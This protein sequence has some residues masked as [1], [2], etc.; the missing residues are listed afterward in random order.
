MQ[1]GPTPPL[2]QAAVRGRAERCRAIDC[3]RG[4]RVRVYTIGGVQ[5]GL[6]GMGEGS[7]KLTFPQRFRIGDALS[8]PHWGRFVTNEEQSQGVW[9]TGGVV[10][11]DDFR[12]AAILYADGTIADEDMPIGIGGDTITALAQVA[13]IYYEEKE[14]ADVQGIETQPTPPPF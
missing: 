2:S 6:V 11:F 3:D 14:C 7:D 1:A 4:P 5:I 13:Q 8:S 9:G 10:A 12:P